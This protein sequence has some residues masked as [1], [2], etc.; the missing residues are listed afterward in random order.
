MNKILRFTFVALLAMVASFSFAQ[1]TI[2][3]DPA[4]DKGPNSSKA[5]KGS[6]TKDGVTIETSN[7]MLGAYNQGT[8]A[9]EYRFYHTDMTVTSTAGT[10][11]KVV[12]TCT[13]SDTEKQGPGCFKLSTGSTGKYT[14]KG[15]IGTW[16]GA[17]TTFSLTASSKQVRCT[18]IEVT[19]STSGSIVAAPTISTISGVE[20]FFD[21]TTVTITAG[22]GADIYYTVDGTDPTTSSTKYSAPFD[23]TETT[24]VK[25]LAAKGGKTSAVA[26][27]TFT[28][29]A[30]LTLEGDGTETNPYTVKD[31]LAIIKAN[32]Q[33]KD[34]VFVVG[35]VKEDAKFNSKHSDCSFDLVEEI[36]GTDAIYA[37]AIKDVNDAAFKDASKLKAGTKVVI[38]TVLAYYN[39]K[40]ELNRGQIAGYITTGIFKIQTSAA[41]SVRYNLAGQKV[42]ADYKGVV[43]ENGKKVVVK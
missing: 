4:T 21:K 34:N 20:N 43:I 5:G 38:K 24:T 11:T 19:V 7:G 31:A 36:N 30:K 29:K 9:Y 10:I 39:G 37:Y 6:V 26:S 16:E 27:K 3:F 23:L 40:A 8:E 2:T 13:A 14:F 12:F 32:E 28:K 35:Y 41:K 33:T 1:T 15:K 22:E 25:A 18:K 42:G 17:A